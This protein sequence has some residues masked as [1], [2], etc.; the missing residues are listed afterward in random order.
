MSSQSEPGVQLACDGCRR[1][2]RQCDGG[3]KCDDGRKNYVGPS[4]LAGASKTRA[5]KTRKS[6]IEALKNR[7]KEVEALLEKNKTQRSPAVQ[8]ISSAIHRLNDPNPFP[9]PHA[10]DLTFCDVA[11][12]FG[13]LAIDGTAAQGFQGKS[14]GA[15][16]VKAAVELKIGRKPTAPPPDFPPISSRIETLDRPTPVY[17]FPDDDLL[18]SLIDLYFSAVN[19]F[20]P[21][22]HRPTFDAAV[23]SRLHLKHAAFAK[24]VLLVCAL[25]ARYS[26]DARVPL[27][28]RPAEDTAGWRWFD[29]VK[30]SGHVL[31]AHPTL[32]DLQS[33]C[34]AA[35]F[36]DC[37]SS[38]RTCWTLVG[39]GT[40]LSQD[41]GAHRYRVRSTLSPFEQELEKR[42]SWILF[43]YDAQTSTAL[44][45]GLALQYYDF[46]LKYPLIVDDEYWSTTSPDRSSPPVPLFRQPADKPSQL[47]FFKCMLH[48]SRIMSFCCKI[49]YSTN[50]SQTLLGLKD[51]PWEEQLVVELDSALNAWF[52]TIPP[53]LRWAPDIVDDTFFDQAAALQCT[54]QH[55]RIIIHR[56]FIPA[57][58]RASP[59][60][61]PSLAICN[62]AARACIH[63]A[64]IQQD[65]RPNNPMWFSQTPLFTSG[66]VLLLNIWGGTN[67]TSNPA[68]ELG[69]S[70]AEKDLADVHRCMAVLSAQ[71]RQWPSA[72]ALL[73]TLSQ[74]V[75][76]DRPVPVPVPSGGQT[77]NHGAA[78]GPEP[79]TADARPAHAPEY[80]P[81]PDLG[82][83]AHA[84]PMPA[85]HRGFP[86]HYADPIP[87]AHDHEHAFAAPPMYDPVLETAPPPHEYLGAELWFSADGGQ[88][89]PQHDQGSGY[90]GS[91]GLLPPDANPPDSYHELSDYVAA[92]GNHDSH[93]HGNLDMAG[94]GFG[95]GGGGEMQSGDAEGQGSGSF[96]TQDVDM[97]VDMQT[98]IALW[99]QAPTS[100]GVADW[101]MYLG[102]FVDNLQQPGPI[103]AY[104]QY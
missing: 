42:A 104:S 39:F 85:L 68:S 30:L 31:H 19:P 76:M 49:L 32:Y 58:R 6:E 82:A 90:M 35:A 81:P 26:T 100:F 57:M 29:Q 63:V 73:E 3:D 7:L 84:P 55:T 97:D 79:S 53:H 74:L 96:T 8:L 4:T 54:A 103:Q 9:A 51:D 72:G 89:G 65:R 101:D 13:F 40:R 94:Y 44:G 11:D 61:L 102:Q 60:H 28:H 36:L 34:L 95:D 45:R 20:L 48:L 83:H 59:T 43:L 86:T 50:R 66:I 24:T 99:S 47:A 5:S 17:D 62:T 67:P 52:D 10:D 14:S 41:I 88:H 22:L 46:D 25:G 71:R 33:Y 92:F 91:Y 16:F 78:R 80:T 69:R 21:L 2:G 77:S 75:A 37:T 27:P 93:D 12:S 56:P 18:A 98:T 87:H 38:P 70:V 1:K 64:Q 23:H 15:M